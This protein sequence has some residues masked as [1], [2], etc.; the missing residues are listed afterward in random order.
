MAIWELLP[1]DKESP[2]WR[3]SRYKERIVVRA[4]SEDKARELVTPKL[5]DAAKTIPGGDTPENPWR[6]SD[7]VV[8]KLLK[9]SRYDE[10]GPDEILEPKE[11][12]G[13]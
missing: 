12:T 10:D 11:L 6:R 2:H 5:Y 3:H 4:P 7:L 1:T 13:L 8:C 9:D